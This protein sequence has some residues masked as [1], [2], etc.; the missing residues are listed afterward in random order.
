MEL[1]GVLAWV[2]WNTFL[3]IV[4]VVLANIIVWLAGLPKRKILKVPVAM[5]GLVWLAFLPNTCYLLTEWRHFLFT[6]D[7]TDLYLQARIDSAMTLRL[8]L[9]TV[10]YFCYSGVGVLTFTLAIR[11][12]ARLAKQKGANLWVYTIPLFLMLSIGVYLGLV[13]RY[14]SW[15]LIS[16]PGE[17]WE[18]VKTLSRRPALS[19][20]IIVFGGFL[21]LAYTAVDIWIDGLIIRWRHL[22]ASRS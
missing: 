20:F 19:A 2:S 6:L 8:M 21:W 16:R 11:P 9:H 10:F 13:L 12:I 3:A 4:P 1:I 17:V 5:L 18:S 22:K 15:D 14:N 7:G